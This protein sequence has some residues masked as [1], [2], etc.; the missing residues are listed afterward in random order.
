MKGV[1]GFVGLDAA[2][3][4]QAR[5]R[6]IANQIQR[7]VPSKLVGKAQ[8]PV[9]NPVV[10]ENDGVLER[11]AAN[12]THGLERLDVTLETESSRSRQKVAESIRPNQ[13]LHFLLAY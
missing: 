11:A 3:Q 8:R 6:E 10:G 5:Q 13:H 2:E 9:H 7:F 4:R 12:E 1:A